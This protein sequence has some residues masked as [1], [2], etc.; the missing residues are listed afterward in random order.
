M[1]PEA[2]V[3]QN[4]DALLA[5]SG[6]HVCDLADATRM[7]VVAKICRL[8]S[9]FREVGLDTNRRRAQMVLNSLLQCNLK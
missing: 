2:R 7:H 3:G 1:T 5:G 4:I 6:R 8:P 9:V